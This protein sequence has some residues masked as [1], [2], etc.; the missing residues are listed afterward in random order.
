MTACWEMLG[1]IHG[2]SE[3]CAPS[4][5]NGRSGCAVSGGALATCPPNTG[6]KLR[7]SIMLGFVSFNSLFGG[8]AAPAPRRGAALP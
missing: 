8:P 3:Y 1:G 4:L 5:V 2:T 6:V 7:S